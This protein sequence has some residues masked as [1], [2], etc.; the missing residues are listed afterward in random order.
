MGQRQLTANGREKKALLTNGKTVYFGQ[1]Q[2]GWYALAEMNLDGGP[3]RVLWNPQANVL[4]IDISPDGKELLALCGTGVEDEREL[5][6]VPVGT[7]APRRLLSITAHSAAWAPDGRTIAYAFGTGIYLTSKD[8]MTPKQAGTFAGT[9]R[10]LN[11]SNDGQ[12][13]RFALDGIATSNA[14][15]W[16]QLSG[17]DMKTITMY[18]LPPSLNGSDDWTPMRGTDAYLVWAGTQNLE[19]SQVWLVR[20]GSRW[21][22]PS[23]HATPV[24]FVQG[25]L[26][27]ITFVPETSRLLALNKPKARTA[28]VRFD[29]RLQTF[30]Q[31][32]PG[33]SGTFLN[34]SRDGKWVS[35]VSYREGALWLSQADG[36]D[37]RQLTFPPDI[38]ELSQ[39]SPDGKRIAYMARRLGGRWRIHIFDVETGKAREAS[40]SDDSQGAPT[41]L[42]MEDSSATDA[43]IARTHTPAKSAGSIW[44]R[45]SA[46][47]AGFGGVVHSP[48]V[49]RWTIHCG[50]SS[51]AASIN[52]VRC[53]GE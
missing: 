15:L 14:V 33:A 53:K 43:S 26:S 23:I 10:S 22:K 17:D 24:P 46:N 36:S 11:W 19:K 18:P 16:G 4:P 42:R 27:G 38:A 45:Q 44:P 25:E 20:Y 52:A 1:E 50:T 32:L 35:Y 30:R 41:C 48:L 13:L 12:S 5:W 29:P 34:Y 28:F 3:I 21:W 47:V 2:N 49:A 7:G 6:I 31:I 40:A 9:P 39:W 37:A 51:G 8:R